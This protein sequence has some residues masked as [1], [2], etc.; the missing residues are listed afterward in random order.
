METR[1]RKYIARLASYRQQHGHCYVWKASAADRSLRRW[2]RET[3]LAHKKG[4]LS[5]DQIAALTELKV[6]F[7]AVGAHWDRW[8]ARYLDL[9]Q[10][11]QK[12]GHTDVSQLVQGLGP[13]LSSQRVMYRQGTLT[14]G[15]RQ[16]LESL[17]VEWYPSQKKGERW[18]EQYAKLVD[19]QKEHGHCNV[20]RRK[21][22]DPG[23][24][25]SAQRTAYRKGLL[26]PERVLLLER[27][28]FL[29]S[30]K[31][32]L[33]APNEWRNDAWTRQCLALEAAGGKAEGALAAWVDRQR[34]AH[35]TGNLSAE[36]ATLL[37]DMGV[38]LD[39]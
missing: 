24:W 33:A 13:W 36:R 22:P 35:R 4:Q 1:F 31:G 30:L 2:L 6:D 18:I 28:G 26:A 9:Q 12:H 23:I 5:A 14:E 19:F 27:L 21:H 10:F 16:L 25:V 7:D 37:Q 32:E 20:S 29:W 3:L 34:E 17:G 39:A 8:E 38:V 15:R 11:A